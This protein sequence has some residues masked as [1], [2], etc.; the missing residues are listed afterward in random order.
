ME[1]PLMFPGDTYP[2]CLCPLDS[3]SNTAPEDRVASLE[4]VAQSNKKLIK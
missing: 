4:H 3:P 1:H 2:A